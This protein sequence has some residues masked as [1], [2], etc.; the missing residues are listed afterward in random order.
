MKDIGKSFKNGQQAEIGTLTFHSWTGSII[1][2]IR[3][4][5]T[6]KEKGVVMMDV[7]EDRF[8]LTNEERIRIREEMKQREMKDFQE[9]EE[10]ANKKLV[11]NNTP[12]KWNR[13]EK[14]NFA[15]PFRSK[16]KEKK[17]NPKPF[18]KKL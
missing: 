8:G 7:I 13:D 6:E 10:K 5:T 3:S 15:S 17:D 2:R 9:R 1:D 16:P 4:K 11:F 18:F 14:G 12:V